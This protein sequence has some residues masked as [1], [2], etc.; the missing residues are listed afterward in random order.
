MDGIYSV[1]ESED[2]ELLFFFSSSSILP[3][4]SSISSSSS[5]FFFVSSDVDYVHISSQIN[6]RIRELSLDDCQ[7]Q[8]DQKEGSDKD[9]DD[10]VNYCEDRKGI[11]DRIH[12]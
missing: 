5:L 11:E 12:D 2:E 7:S 6:L 10:E 8:I 1:S 4:S 3:S 9:Q